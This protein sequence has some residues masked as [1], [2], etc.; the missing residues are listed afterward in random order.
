MLPFGKRNVKYRSRRYLTF[1]AYEGSTAPRSATNRHSTFTPCPCSCAAVAS[2]SGRGGDED[3]RPV[4]PTGKQH[5]VGVDTELEGVAH[6]RRA[7]MAFGARVGPGAGSAF[8]AGALLPHEVGPPGQQ[9]AVELQ[10]LGA[11]LG[12]ALAQVAARAMAPLAV[13]V[14][15]AEATRP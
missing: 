12:D 13:A 8:G 15:G 2:S 1:R 4:A 5:A 11:E 7:R 3:D 9:H 10:P 14:P 6:V